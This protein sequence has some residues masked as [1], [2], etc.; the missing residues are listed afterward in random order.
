MIQNIILLSFIIIIFFFISNEEKINDFIST[1]NFKYLL[2]IVIVYYVY[3]N[4]NIILLIVL[5]LIFIFLNMKDNKY[6]S[7]LENFNFSDLKLD[8]FKNIINEYYNQHVPKEKFSNNKDEYDIKP[9][10]PLKNEKEEIILNKEEKTIEP[11]KE[12][13]SKLKDLYENIKNEIN[14]LK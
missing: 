9:Y 7:K 5:I 14:K 12:E 2:L 11:F 1:K 3:Q 4:Y 6:L 10:T 8:N 13:V